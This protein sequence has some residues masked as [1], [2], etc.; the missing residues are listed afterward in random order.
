MT[1]HVV[2]ALW[3][4]RDLLSAAFRERLDSAWVQVNVDDDAVAA[5]QLRLTTFAQPVGAFVTLPADARPDGVLADFC[6][7]YAGW[8]VETEQPIEPPNVPSGE[9]ADALTNVA[10]LRRPVELPYDVWLRRW[11]Q[12]HTPVGIADQGN[13][14]YV[15][16]RVLEPVTPNA[17]E[18]AAIVEEL[19]S[20]E[21][22]T[23]LH[24]FYGSGGDD[25]L[26]SERMGR[27]LESVA[28]FG[29][30][31]DVDVV[32]TSRYRWTG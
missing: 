18:V 5:A 19:F 4:P 27:M 31:R 17:P 28:R 11:K 8:G 12:D 7:R 22:M 23:D 21:A 15:Q 25:A 6:T 9:R 20:M 13:F 29:A 10:V 16:H 32:P 24:A 14:G 3:E 2:Y 30:D 1:E 26:L